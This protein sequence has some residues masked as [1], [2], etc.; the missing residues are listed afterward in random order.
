TVT[1]CEFSQ[2]VPLTMPPAARQK[3]SKGPTAFFGSKKARLDPQLPGRM[4]VAK[5]TLPPVLIGPPLSV[6]YVTVAPTTAS[7]VTD[8]GLGSALA[9]FLLSVLSS[10][11]LAIS[12][13]AASARCGPLQLML[14]LLNFVIG[15]LM[16]TRPVFLSDWKRSFC[17]TMRLADVVILSGA[18]MP[19]TSG[20]S[21]P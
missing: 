15:E 19:G 7:F 12:A 17:S 14:L 8:D 3:P 10:T 11:M 9:P 6:S 2:A 16:P 1:P 5:F 13:F 18:I 4:S 21:W 20:S